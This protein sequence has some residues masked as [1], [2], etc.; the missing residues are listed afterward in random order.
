MPQRVVD[1]LE[2]VEVDQEQGGHAVRVLVPELLVTPAEQVSPVGQRGQRVMGRG[3]GVLGGDPGQ[4]GVRGRVADGGAQ[5][6]GERPEGVP[7]PLGELDRIPEPEPD[8]ADVGPVVVPFE[9][10]GI[11]R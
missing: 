2:V 1:L 8:G 7:L 4:F 9:G 11:V 10:A 3:M 6:R 5:R